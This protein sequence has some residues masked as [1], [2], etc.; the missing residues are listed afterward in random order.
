[1]MDVPEFGERLQSISR[2]AGLSLREAEVVVLVANGA[3]EREM[4][5]TLGISAHTVHSH[6]QRA[7]Q[8]LEVNSRSGMLGRL[9]RIAL[10]QIEQEGCRPD[11]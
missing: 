4:A 8:K 11:D 6:L 9:L 1:M 10:D 7:F 3:T 2:G 5:D